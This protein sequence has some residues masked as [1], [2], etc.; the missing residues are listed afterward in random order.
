MMGAVDKID[1]VLNSVN[2]I[3]KC[4]KSDIKNIFS[5]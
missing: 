4:L 1:M 5:I 2:C 3:R